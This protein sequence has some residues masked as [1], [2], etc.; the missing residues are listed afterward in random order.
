MTAKGRAPKKAKF[1]CGLAVAAATT[2]R[3]I[4]TTRGANAANSVIA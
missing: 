1:G 2:R 3:T 4:A